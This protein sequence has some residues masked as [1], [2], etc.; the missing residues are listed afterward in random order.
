MA[1]EPGATADHRVRLLAVPAHLADAA[2]AGDL[3]ALTPD[4]PGSLHRGQGWPHDDSGHALAFT[5]VGGQ[6]YLVVDESGAVVGEA[7]TKGAA[8]PDGHVEIGYG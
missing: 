1:A 4:Q 2:L 8:A 5:R 6:T 7:G 3:D